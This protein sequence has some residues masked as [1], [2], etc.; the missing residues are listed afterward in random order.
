MSEALVDGE[1]GW[2]QS[3]PTDRFFFFFSCEPKDCVWLPPIPISALSWSASQPHRPPPLS[4]KSAFLSSCPCQPRLI[5]SLASRPGPDEEMIVYFVGESPAASKAWTSRCPLSAKAGLPGDRLSPDDGLKARNAVS[6]EDQDLIQ[7][8]RKPRR[9]VA[10]FGL[11]VSP[12]DASSTGS[13]FPP[14]TF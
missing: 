7:P 13:N 11:V 4:P 9:T 14:R 10:S 6:R 8:I 12:S 3:S 2:V 1:R 5:A